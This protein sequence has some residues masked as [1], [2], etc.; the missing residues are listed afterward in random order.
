MHVVTNVIRFS[1][2]NLCISI[3]FKIW[4]HLY[5]V[6]IVKYIFFLRNAVCYFSSPKTKNWNWQGSLLYCQSIVY[7]YI[8][9]ISWI[10]PITRIGDRVHAFVLSLLKSSSVVKH[11]ALLWIGRCISANAG[12]LINILSR[13][14]GR[15]NGWYFILKK[16]SIET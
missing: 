4:F 16:G 2:S 12:L 13:L 9:C 3:L 5:C 14:F 10:Q 7:Y 8:T 15:L 6:L 11:K 1:P